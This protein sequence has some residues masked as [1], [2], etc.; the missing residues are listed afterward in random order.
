VPILPAQP[1]GSVASVRTEAGPGSEA[2]LLEAASRGDEV[3]FAALAEPHRRALHLHCYRMLGSLH[4]ADDALQETLL[5]AWRNL[6]RFTPRPSLRAWLHT[7]A[8]NVC[9]TALERRRRRRE[10]PLPPPEADA[11]RTE[12]LHL[13][14]YPDRLLD[15]VETRETVEL[16]FVAAVQ[17]LPPKQRA[18][19]ILRDVLGWSAKEAAEAL[20]DSVAAVNSALQRARAGLDRARAL[21]A[22]RHRPPPGEEERALV[23]RFVEAWNSV[24]IDGLVALLARDAVMTMPPEPM[25]VRGA[26]EIGAFFASVPAEGRLDEIRLV[27][28]TANRQPALAAYVLD[29]ADGTYRAYG[30]M[31]LSLYGNAIDGIV[32]FADV[33]I[34]EHLGMPSELEG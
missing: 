21:S 4:D 17:L 25:Y 27:P 23:A 33:S 13:Q 16:A 14:P 10:V 19:L 5:R 32:G 22:P 15:D 7:I 24:D 9:L 3:A 30:L 12:L 11:W 6:P 8:T 34:F 29:R 31:V 20:E 1:P 26:R 2:S 28:T 18:V